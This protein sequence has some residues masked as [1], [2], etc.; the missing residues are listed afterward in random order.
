MGL[1]KEERRKGKKSR[2]KRI[3]LNF[4]GLIDKSENIEER[5]IPPGETGFGNEKG[6]FSGCL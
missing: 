4:E 5:E 3:D 6:A 2:G 1:K